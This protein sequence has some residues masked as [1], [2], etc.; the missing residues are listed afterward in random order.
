M[1][2]Y[3]EAHSIYEN[4][5]EAEPD[6]T[7][8]AVGLSHIES[9]IGVWHLSQGTAAH[10]QAASEWLDRAGERLTSLRDI[11]HVG[12]HQREISRILD[13]IHANQKL[14]LRRSKAHSPGQE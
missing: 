13:T 1:E 14:I 3:M 10:D 7:D 5:L 2:H 6:V 8:H 11:K 9:R 4:L 12:S